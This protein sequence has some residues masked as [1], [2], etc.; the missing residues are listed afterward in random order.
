VMPPWPY[1]G[2]YVWR[3]L[4][5]WTSL[6]VGALAVGGPIY[7]TVRGFIFALAVTIVVLLGDAERRT[8]R[9]FLAN[10]GVSRYAISSVITTTAL[11]L[12]STVRLVTGGSA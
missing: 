2:A 1:I 7:F 8:E 11:A 6:H 12:E 10:L 3:T 4:I 5:V 9:R